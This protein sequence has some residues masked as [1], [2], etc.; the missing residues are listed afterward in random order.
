SRSG[1]YQAAIVDIALGDYAVERRY[2]TL[3]G[4]L[5]PEDSYLGFLGGDVRLGHADRSLL[6]L[7]GQAIIVALLQREPTLLDEIAVARV[8]DLGEIAARLCLLQCRLVLGQR[9]LGLRD[10]VVEL[11]SGD[12]RQQRAS[13]D[14]IADIDIALFDV[15]AGARENIRRLERRGRRGQGDGDLV[16]AGP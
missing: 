16:V 10:L 15:A 6:G 12:V 1:R 9:R 8:G 11:G 13:L 4:L 14:P 3:V 5:L 7:Q 2:D